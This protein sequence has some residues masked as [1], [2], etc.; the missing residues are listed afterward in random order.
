M[1]TTTAPLTAETRHTIVLEDVLQQISADI[2][3]IGDRLLQENQQQKEQNIQLLT[4]KLDLANANLAFLVKEVPDFETYLQ[5][6]TWDKSAFVSAQSAHIK[7][8]RGAH[9]IEHFGHLDTGTLAIVLVKCQFKLARL[10]LGDEM[11]V[12]SY[13]LQIHPD[14]LARLD[15]K[16]LF[17]R[18]DSFSTPIKLLHE[19]A[20]LFTLR[21]QNHKALHR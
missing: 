13:Y 19:L 17:H 16:S 6:H 12:D 14:N 4:A 18:L 20:I 2:H 1:N 15:Q 8:V 3:N 5:Q 9:P 21:E 10:I 11:M 7:L